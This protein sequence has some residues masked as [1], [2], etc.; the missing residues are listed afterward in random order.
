MTI[1]AAV[2]TVMSYAVTSFVTSEKVFEGTAPYHNGRNDLFVD[3]CKAIAAKGVDVVDDCIENVYKIIF[4]VDHDG[5]AL[6]EKD[7]KTLIE[8]VRGMITSE[9]VDRKGKLMQAGIV[10]GIVSSHS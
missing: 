5:E 10:F 6:D 8:Y 1:D 7:A 3:V 2:K 4:N 9:V